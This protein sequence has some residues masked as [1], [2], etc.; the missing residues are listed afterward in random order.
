MKLS[1]RQWFSI[2]YFIPCFS[3]QSSPLPKQQQQQSTG[4]STP[5]Y[6]QNSLISLTRDSSLS[7]TAKWDSR[8]S[9]SSCSNKIRLRW[10]IHCRRSLCMSD[11]LRTE[12]AITKPHASSLSHQPHREIPEKPSTL[13]QSSILIECPPTRRSLSYSVNQTGHASHSNR[14]GCLINANSN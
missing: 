7:L 8:S 5:I 11:G 4:S 12:L 1:P 2:Q 6:P 3:R 9:S 10:S 14:I 13:S